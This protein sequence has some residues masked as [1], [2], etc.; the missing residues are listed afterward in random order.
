[1]LKI[2]IYFGKQLTAFENGFYFGNLHT[3]RFARVI[4]ANFCLWP[5]YLHQTLTKS[6]VHGIIHIINLYA[7]FM[8]KYKIRHI[9]KGVPNEDQRNN[10]GLQL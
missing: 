7:D 8:Q 10:A 3:S 4:S 9:P 1:M 6:D 5:L 2:A